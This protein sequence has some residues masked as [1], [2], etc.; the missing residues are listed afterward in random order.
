RIEL[1]QGLESVR[2]HD[3]NHTRIVELA[4]AGA[5]P[6]KEIGLFA[7]PPD[8]HFD[9]AQ[10]WQIKLLVQR[11]VGALQ[12]AFLMFDL[13]Y[14]PPEKYLRT[15]QAAFGVPAWAP[16]A[17]PEAGSASPAAMQAPTE[18]GAA[19]E[20]PLWQRIW[21]TRWLDVGILS[22]LII[23]LTG[24]FFFQ[25]WLT[26]R[27]KLFVLVRYGFLAF[28]LLWLGWL[29]HAQPSVVNVLTYVNA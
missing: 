12:K 2:F 28:V 19:T 6:F 7:I 17:Q 22:V 4:A 3:R 11:A 5:P 24:I 14:L 16:G 29:V 23:G 9:A 1:V 10:P 26:R 27:P 21:K 13:R 25:D 15:E 8:A 20:T 18:A